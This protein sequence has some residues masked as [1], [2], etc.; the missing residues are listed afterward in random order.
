MMLFGPPEAEPRVNG[1]PGTGVRAPVSMVTDSTTTSF[2][3]LSANNSAPYTP[4]V[5]CEFA[6]PAVDAI[7]VNA[8]VDAMEKPKI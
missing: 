8:P 4:A 2:D 3:E 6:G 1:E 7:G 5:L